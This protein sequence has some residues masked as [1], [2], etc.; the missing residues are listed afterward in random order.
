MN[1]RYYITTPIYYASDAPHLGH[2]YTTIIGDV[3]ARYQRMR[4]KQV[5][6]LTG[7]DEHGEKMER[8]AKAHHQAPQAFVEKMAH[9]YKKMW[10]AMHIQ[11][12]DFIRTT[13]ERHKEEVQKLWTKLLNQGDIY[14]GSYEGWYCVAC[15]SFYLEKDLLPGNCC[16]DHKRPVEKVKEDGYFFR[17]SRYEQAL[18][19]LY[20]TN[21]HFVEPAMRL[22]EVKAFVK[23]GLKDLSVSR[24]S[25][26][27]GIPVPGDEKHVIYVWIDALTNYYSALQKPSDRQAFWG[28]K[29]HPLAIHLM[30]KEITRFHAVYWPALL[31]AASLPLPQKIVAHGWWTVDGE[32]MSKTLGNVV[33]PGV[34]AQD[35]GADALRY[36][37]LREVPLGQ[38]G[39]FSYDALLHRYNSELA[40]DLGNLLH[41]TL[42]MIEKF[43]GG[44][45]VLGATHSASHRLPDKASA[46]A[47]HVEQAMATFQP[48]AALVALFDFV[49]EANAY[50]EQEA[51]F[52]LAKTNPEAAQAV[53]YQA[54]EALR[55]LGMLLHPFVPERARELRKQ[56]GLSD[57]DEV[58]WPQTWGE[59]PEGTQVKKGEPLFPRLDPDKQQ[60]LLDK[61][62]ASR[63]AA[64][65]QPTSTELPQKPLISFA[66]FQKLDIRVGTVQAAERIKNKDKLLQLQIDIGTE[67]R[68][69]V[70]GIGQVYAPETLVGAQV[71]LVANLQPA[72]IG[73]VLSQGMI[74]A[75][76]DKD[77]LG[78]LQPTT[79]VPA[80]SPVR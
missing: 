40:N 77:I 4:G 55:W 73:G 52:R 15:E 2:A 3:V 76:G 68:T 38:D 17:L 8:A 7:T 80:G 26:S 6:Y 18:L 11:Y 61:W 58:I 75:I 42:S 51:P 44:R 43:S 13:E 20:E 12:D 31:M 22:N 32:K 65:P 64:Q 25:F 48:S 59:L 39:D 21:P 9:L 35:L 36:F 70:A 1:E 47:N 30:G 24:S 54:A 67:T 53:L 79:N 63:R 14:R 10:D 72:K 56:L 45:A 60:A 46:T 74:L 78:L 23:G 33:D 27:W 62:R 50:L 5:F 16:P 57:P 34:L 66:D 41:R 69:V 37:V 49:R 19:E 29:E 71:A 28:T